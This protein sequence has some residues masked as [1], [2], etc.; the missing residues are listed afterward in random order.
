MQAA[1]ALL[2]WLGL[3]TV[4]THLA[5]RWVQRVRVRERL[6]ADVDPAA[7]RRASERTGGEPEGLL[8]R[9]LLL[10][11]YGA[12]GAPTLFG[13]LTALSL[14]VGLTVAW[15]VVRS[16]LSDAAITAISVV[17][18]GVADLFV[19]ILQGAPFII[20]TLFA[21]TPW[22]VVSRARQARVDEVERDLPVLLELLATLGEAGL[23]FDAALD[24]ILDGQP[25]G[26][27][28]AD[29]LRG[30]QRDAQAGIS[31][32]LALRAVARRLDVPSVSV[33]VSGL[34]QAEQIGSSLTEALRRQADDLRNRRRERALMKAEALPVKLVFPLVICFLPGIFI[35][36]L[37]PAFYQFLQVAD[38]A[39][40]G[41]R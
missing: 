19:P 18:G 12:P 35:L 34:V 10:A 16:G 38:G 22:L 30:Y 17:P 31:R 5:L 1:L 11:G 23:G 9:W 27:A 21:F 4:A 39:I 25:P 6:F 33:L 24:R 32:L 2:L 41:G 40:R 15:V 29:E 7:A 28:L 26:R 37:G 20:V 36:T 13:A 14:A 3:M 8:G